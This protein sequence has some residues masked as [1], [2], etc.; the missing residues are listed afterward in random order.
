M[1]KEPREPVKE[2]FISSTLCDQIWL[3]RATLT[4]EVDGGLPAHVGRVML[5]E[6]DQFKNNYNPLSI[7]H[8][9]PCVIMMPKSRG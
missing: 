3:L 6:Y 2:I 9:F 5:G 7:S 4:T 8:H 1:Q